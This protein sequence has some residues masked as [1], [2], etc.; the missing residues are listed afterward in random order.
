[1]TIR[2]G[3]LLHL[4]Y[5]QKPGEAAVH[6]PDGRLLRPGT[7]PLDIAEVFRNARTGEPIGFDDGRIAGVIERADADALRIRVVHTRR[8]VERLYSD[9]GINLPETALDLPA[10]SDEDLRDLDFVARHADIIGL[11]FTNDASDVRF[12]F[13]RLRQMGKQDVGVI[14]KIETRRGCANLPGILIEAMKLPNF[15]VMVARGDL[16]AECGFERLADL[17]DDLLRLCEAAH[18]PLVWATGVLDSLARRGHPTRAEMTDAAAA[19]RAECVMLG[20]GRHIADAV[21][22]LDGLLGRMQDRE[23]KHQ[24]LLGRLG[25][26]PAPGIERE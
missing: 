12:L 8:P 3:D 9:K 21:R 14:F 13:E 20:K 23:Y 6:D 11:S 16:A 7:I 24:C 22:T 4:V 19:Q 25:L 2:A 5:G 17:Q 15:G 26:E 10:L 18:I 1:M